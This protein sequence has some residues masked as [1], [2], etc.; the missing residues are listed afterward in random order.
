MYSAKS[1]AG[2]EIY[3]L[4]LV[5]TMFADIGAIVDKTILELLKLCITCVPSFIPIKLTSLELI[6]MLAKYTTHID[7]GTLTPSLKTSRFRSYM[8]IAIS[9]KAIACLNTLMEWQ[10]NLRSFII[11]GLSEYAV[12]IA[13]S[14]YKVS[15]M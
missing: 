11:H 4:F 6:H 7:K 15:L 10:P 2:T 14:R 5:D 9:E 12:S 8:I 13:D 1:S 3:L